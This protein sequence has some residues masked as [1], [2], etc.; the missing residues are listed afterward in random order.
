MTLPAP[1]FAAL[2]A[3]GPGDR[4]IERTRDL[5]ASIVAY[6]PPPWTLVLVDDHSPERSLADA[7]PAPRGVSVVSV[8]HDRAGK[9][10]AYTAAKG[11]CSVILTGMQWIAR[12]CPDVAFTLKLDTDALVIAPFSSRL[13][14]LIAGEPDVGMIGAFDK[15]PNGDPR[16]VTRAA[17]IVSRLHHPPLPWAQPRKLL[18]HLQE[19]LTGA[20]ALQIRRHIST[21]IDNGYVYGQHCLGGAYAVSGEFLRRMRA[22][23]FLAQPKN[24]MGIDC[25]EDV[26]IGMYTRAVALR[27]RSFVAPGE[28]F[29]IRFM[30]LADTPENLVAR[31]YGVIHAVKNDP[32]FTEDHIRDFF[33]ARRKH[34]SVG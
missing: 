2:V 7:L 4:E 29:G 6:E 1:R 9:K 30:G 3:V 8:H 5:L 22:A 18:R 10:H 13:S 27:H 28:T 32:K 26:M 16:D 34:A 31:G 20:P 17:G 12:T 15:T 25:P 19:Q 11:I 33:R 23:G 21:A 24:W 14:S